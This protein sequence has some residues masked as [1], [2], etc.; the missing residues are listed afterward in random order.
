MIVEIYI[1]CLFTFTFYDCFNLHFVHAH[2]DGIDLRQGPRVSLR[3]PPQY[4]QTVSVVSQSVSSIV[5]TPGHRTLAFTF[6]PNR[7]LARQAQCFLHSYYTCSLRNSCLLHLLQQL[8]TTGPITVLGLS[9][10]WAYYC[11][12]PITVLGLLPYWTDYRSVPI[13]ELVLLPDCAY[14]LN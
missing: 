14:Y 1:L 5:C 9:P 4:M 7:R 10:Y 11:T 12:S 3:A 2:V 13:T 8:L 6:Y